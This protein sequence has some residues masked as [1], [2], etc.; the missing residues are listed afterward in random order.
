MEAA[1]LKARR[2]IGG[3][4]PLSSDCGALCGSA[5]CRADEDG[6][7]GVYLFPG[8]DKLLP[9]TDG[10]FAPL[11]TCEGACDRDRRPLGCRIFPLTPVKSASGWTV[12]IDRRAR[13]MCPL[14]ECGLKGLNPAFVRAV[15]R[16]IRTIASEPEGEAFLQKW[17][18][19]EDAFRSAKL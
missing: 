8:E 15:A 12:R 10:G 3:L 19:L 4:T 17:Q 6:Q 2:E 9:G 1:V 11:H 13:A 7:G 14:A 16:A 18:V 5:C